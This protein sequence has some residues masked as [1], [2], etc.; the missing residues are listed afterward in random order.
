MPNWCE[1]TLKVRGE[2]NNVVKFFRENL[3]IVNFFGNF[4]DNGLTIENYSDSVELELKN[5]GYIKGTHRNF[6]ESDYISI[7]QRKDN[8][9]CVAIHIKGAWAIDFEPYVEM[10]KGYG[11]DIKI[12]TFERGMEFSQ[13]ILIEKGQLIENKEIKYDDYTWECVCPNLGG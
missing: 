12:Q 11:V 3:K 5:T 9:A 4:V 10:S 8:T 13:Y 1:G 6:T 2:Y 7:Y